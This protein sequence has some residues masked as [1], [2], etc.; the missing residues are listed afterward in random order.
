MMATPIPS[1]KT[2]RKVAAKWQSILA[3][4]EWD[5][6][7]RWATAKDIAD[8]SFDNDVAGSCQWQVEHK[9][10]LI[11][12]SRKHLTEPQGYEG[13]IIHELLH[14]RN[15]GHRDRAVKYDSHYEYAIN[16]TMRALMATHN[17][18]VQVA[19]A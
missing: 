11:L 13:T 19:D 10:C 2:L 5:I 14:L 6:D 15:E 18:K 17:E 3:L 1:L 4:D 8:G 12:L 16:C 9:Y 7:I